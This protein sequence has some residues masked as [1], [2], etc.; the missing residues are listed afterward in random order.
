MISPNVETLRDLFTLVYSPLKLRGKATSTKQQY[1]IQIRHLHRFLGRDAKLID[2]DDELISSFLGWI[3]DQGK[4]PA[5]ANK[6]RNH[7]LAL[8]RMAARKRLV[9]KFPDVP[10]EREPERIPSAWTAD[11]LRKLFISC[12]QEPGHLAG[13]AA[14]K[15][16]TALHHCMWDSGE[17]IGALLRLRWQHVDLESAWLIIPAELRKGKRQDKSFRLHADTV[18]ALKAIREPARPIIFEWPKNVLLIYRDYRRILERAGLPTDRRSKFHRMRRST[19]SHF[20]AAGGNATELLGHTSRRTT[21]AYL[22]PRIIQPPQASDVLF[23]PN[24]PKQPPLF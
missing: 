12:Q 20:E 16:W 10:A 14:C 5:T 19:A 11:D 3:V 22:D 17:R 23:R 7:I 13:V 6:A 1:L 8:W 9:E 21:N 4:S 18:A 2:L 24:Q 15:W